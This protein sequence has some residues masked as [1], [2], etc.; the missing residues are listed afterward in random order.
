MQDSNLV[1][2]AQFAENNINFCYLQKIT[3][4]FQFTEDN[5][6]AALVLSTEESNLV[7]LPLSTEDIN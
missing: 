6:F 5:N 7:A 2:F 3:I 4:N 1:V